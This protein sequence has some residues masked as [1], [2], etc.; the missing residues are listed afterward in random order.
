MYSITL[1]KTLTRRVYID[2]A[3]DFDSAAEWARAHHGEVDFGA[4]TPF[5]VE[6]LDDG[7]AERFV[8]QGVEGREGLPA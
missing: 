3:D 6:A 8:A 7:A 1:A 5:F 2:D 4:G